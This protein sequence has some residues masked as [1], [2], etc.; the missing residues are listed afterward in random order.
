MRAKKGFTLVELA[1]V[2]VVIG[3][4]L[5]M[6]IK[7]KDLIDSAKYKTDLTKIDKISSAVSVYYS[8]FSRLPG[9]ANGVGYIVAANSKEAFDNITAQGILAAKDFQSEIGASDNSTNGA[10][11]HFT[12]CGKSTTDNDFVSG[13]G[14]GT[15]IYLSK[16]A[17]DDEAT[18]STAN[19]DAGNLRHLCSIEAGL[20][21]K[22]PTNGFVRK[23][24]GA[25]IAAA[26]LDA[27]GKFEADGPGACAE[28]NAG[29]DLNYLV[30]VW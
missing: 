7:G 14:T 28:K 18:Y 3:L 29:G 13:S 21:D 19:N 30:K 5:G 22:D 4:I 12:Q 8:K 16:T 11:Y 25:V 23:E 6:A 2:L 20:D 9:D 10:F 24:D 27:D 26:E 17:I 1:I 15:C